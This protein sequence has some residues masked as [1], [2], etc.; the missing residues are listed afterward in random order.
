MNRDALLEIAGSRVL[1]LADKALYWPEKELLCIADVHFG[2]AAAYR[3]LGQPVP[4]GTT[5]ANLQRIDRLLV[6]YRT[7]RLVFLGDFLH[8]AKAR[9]ALTLEAVQAWRLRHAAVACVLIRGNHDRRA[10]DP[11]GEM[12]I[13]VVDEPLL[14]GPFALRHTPVAQQGHHVIA[15]HSHPVF[16][17]QGRGRQS[18]RLPC[19]HS[20]DALTV[21]PSF[22]D[23]TGGHAIEPRLGR[24]IFVCDGSSVWPLP[25]PPS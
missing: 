5:L 22:G 16:H 18:L 2:K 1:L 13:Q 6:H 19:F 15:G 8:S 11:P 12:N 24:R 25:S 14:L 20:S 7:T 23:F 4:R 17:L 3:A 10:G 9:A 21:L